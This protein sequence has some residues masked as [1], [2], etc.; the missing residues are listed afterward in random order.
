[1][2]AAE[3]AEELGFPVVLKIVS[4]D[5]R[6][7]EVER[8]R[9]Q[10]RSRNRVGCQFA[11]PLFSAAPPGPRA[12]HGLATCAI[13]ETTLSVPHSAANLT[14]F[15]APD[16]SGHGARAMS[17]SGVRLE[18][19]A[20]LCGHSGTSVTERVYRHQ[21]RP[22]LLDGAVAMDRIFETREKGNPAA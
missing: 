1:V 8:G 6:A 19:I 16:Q 5:R 22:V 21:L 10:R 2:A 18:D 20:D 13:G 14:R 4:P 12:T 11:I 7:H 17:D 9:T 3:L 15:L